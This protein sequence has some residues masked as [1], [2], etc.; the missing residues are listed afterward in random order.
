MQEQ[1]LSEKLLREIGGESP[2]SNQLET[3]Q[4][5]AWQREDRER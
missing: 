4:L 1:M 5:A 3:D 2:Q